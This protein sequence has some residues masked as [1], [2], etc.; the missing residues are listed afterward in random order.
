[1]KVSESALDAKVKRSNPKLGTSLHCACFNGNME[2]VKL[3]I[4]RGADKE[5]RNVS[6]QTPLIV[7]S[8]KG[9]PDVVDYL[10]NVDASIHPYCHQRRTALHY[11]CKKKH[12]KVVKILIE[13]NAN[14]NSRDISG[15]TPAM[16]EEQPAHC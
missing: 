10:L 9:H 12:F 4:N 6:G 5:S 1:M 8:L 3:L 14:V 11:A 16:L 7:A 15:N 2:I 13:H